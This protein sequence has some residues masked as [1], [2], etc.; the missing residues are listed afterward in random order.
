MDV[1]VGQFSKQGACICLK[2][3]FWN[4]GK[5]DVKKKNQLL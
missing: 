2:N 3:Y 1:E 4:A 5:R